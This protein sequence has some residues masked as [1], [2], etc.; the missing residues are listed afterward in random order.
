MMSLD[1]RTERPE[2]L[3]IGVSFSTKRGNS[4][5][6]DGRERWWDVTTTINGFNGAGGYWVT[7][8]WRWNGSAH[9][10]RRDIRSLSAE[11]SRE[12]DVTYRSTRP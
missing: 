11:Q 5:Q 3:D 4:W 10:L 12:L 9:A 8:E 6:W 7:E 2:G 1:L